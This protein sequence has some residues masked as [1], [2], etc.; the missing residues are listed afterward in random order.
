M[1][2]SLPNIAIFFYA[3]F[4]KYFKKNSTNNKIMLA[5]AKVHK[6]NWKTEK[7]FWTAKDPGKISLSSRPRLRETLIDGPGEKRA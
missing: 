7:N 5:Q 2:W 1:L 3:G 4:K 6:A